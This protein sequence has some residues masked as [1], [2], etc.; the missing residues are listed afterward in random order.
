M[1]S[2]PTQLSIPKLRVQF[3]GKAIAPG[4]DQYDEMRATFYGGM[5]HRPSVIIRAANAIDVADVIAVARDSGHELS[6]RSGGHSLA[7]HGVSDGGIMLDVSGMRSLEIDA[8]DRTAWVEP[9]LTAGEYSVAAAAHGLATGS[10]MPVRSGSAGSRWAGDRAPRPQARP[11]DRCPA[12]GRSRDRG[13]TG[14]ARGCGHEHGPVLGD[15]R[16]GGNFGVV[17]RMRFRC[18][19]SPRSSA[20]SSSCRRRPTSSPRS[21]PRPRPHRRNSRRS[22]TSWSPRRCRSCRP[23]RTASS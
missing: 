4:D 16:G 6:V 20:A 12:R 3:D 2:V 8:E 9:G 15:P 11:H 23:R 14:P 22:R 19:R 10:A 1:R 18:S 7:G 5:N 17:T 13:R 21:S